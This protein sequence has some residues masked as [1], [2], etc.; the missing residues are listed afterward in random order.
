MAK[1]KRKPGVIR[2]EEKHK[3]QRKKRAMKF[4]CT[5]LLIVHIF[6]V[7]AHIYRSWRCAYTISQ[8]QLP[9]FDDVVIANIF[10]A[11]GVTGIIAQFSDRFKLDE[12]KPFKM[13]GVGAIV[14]IFGVVLVSLHIFTDSFCT[15]LL[16][17]LGWI[18]INA[19]IGILFIGME[20]L[21]ADLYKNFDDE[22]LKR[23]F[24]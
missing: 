8:E 16:E 3:K 18:P 17:Y 9:A 14:L 5:F 7:F 24:K 21:K 15:I 19:G 11:W 1:G 23:F 10:C 6:L 4:F 20:H 2:T 22:K 12:E 13:Y